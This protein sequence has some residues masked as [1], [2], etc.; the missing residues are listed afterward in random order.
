MCC[1]RAKD[2]Q[3]VRLKHHLKYTH[4]SYCES[5]SYIH[6]H[7]HHSQQK[8]FFSQDAYSEVASL[9]AEF[10]RDLDIVLSDIIAGLVLLRQRQ[11]AKRSAILDQ[12]CRIVALPYQFHYFRLN[13]Y[14]SKNS[15][16][17]RLQANNDVLAFLSGMP[18]TRKTKYLD[19]KN[20]VFQE[21][22]KGVCL[23]RY[24]FFY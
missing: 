23:C 19:L 2:T 13:E 20:S 18:V 9:F 1:T 16:S 12:V 17:V 8:I 24:M 11:R 14:S 22:S 21:Y 10:F 4:A 6:T 7:T 5:V 3:S 15:F